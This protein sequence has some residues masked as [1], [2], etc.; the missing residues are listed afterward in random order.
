MEKVKRFSNDER[1]LYLYFISALLEHRYKKIVIKIVTRF[2]N[3]KQMK[4]W[5]TDGGGLKMLLM[6]L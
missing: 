1:P 4:I 2:P 5:K 6:S 3:K